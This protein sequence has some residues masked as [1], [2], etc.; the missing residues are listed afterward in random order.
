M[1]GRGP[2][3]R[4]GAAD[5]CDDDRLSDL[6]GAARGNQK[7]VDV[8][9][10][11]DEQQD[12]VGR[13]VMHHVVQKFAGAE[14]ALVAGADAIG[15]GNAE[16]LGAMLDGK[17]DAAGL[18]DD[19]DPARGRGERNMTRLDVDRW[20]ESRRDLLHFTEKTFRVGT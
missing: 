20:T 16:R 2:L 4:A 14:I 9:D 5:F 3:A 7:L 17:T 12:H 11:L 15:D 10:A 8:A 1:R 19:G 18:R 13:G 6:G